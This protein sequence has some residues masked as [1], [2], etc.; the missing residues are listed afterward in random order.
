MDSSRL[1]SNSTSRI[2]TLG[3]KCYILCEASNEKTWKLSYFIVGTYGNYLLGVPNNPQ[4]FENLFRSCGGI[5]HFLIINWDNSNNHDCSYLF[6]KYGASAIFSKKV[7]DSFPCQIYNDPLLV[8]LKIVL[9]DENTSLIWLM[10]YADYKIC[11]SRD[12]GYVSGR[13]VSNENLDNIMRAYKILP[14][15]C[16]GDL[17][18]L[19]LEIV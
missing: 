18:D 14:G 10:E 17:Q 2:L 6:K 11:I 3:N 19:S 15:W 4:I 12:I 1:L 7:S 9:H 5:K 13:F 16:Q 8:E